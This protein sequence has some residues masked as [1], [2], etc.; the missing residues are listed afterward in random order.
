M[1]LQ[2]WMPLNGNLNNQG[3]N[4]D[5]SLMTSGTIAYTNNGKI[6]KALTTGAV[7]IPASMNAKIMN[8]NE[9]S[10]AF[11]VYINLEDG[12]TSNRSMFFGSDSLRWFSLFN[13]P[14]ANDLHW[15]W[16]N[17]PIGSS[18]NA[19]GVTRIS[20]GVKYGVIPTKK[21]FHL[22]ATYNRTK[23]TLYVDG[24]IVH[25]SNINTPA[26]VS[27]YA[28][29]IPMIHNNNYYYYND[30]RIYDHCLSSKE[31][32][33]IAK[34]L[35]LH[36]KL[37]GVGGNLIK[38]S[39]TAPSG[40]HDYTGKA[41]ASRTVGE[42]SV[43]TNIYNIT[44]PADTATYSNYNLYVFFTR[45]TT[46]AAQQNGKTYTLSFKI[47]ASKPLSS[48]TILYE[49]LNVTKTID[50]GTDWITVTMTGAATGSYSA[51]YL[52]YSQAN[53]NKINGGVLSIA[54]LKL[55]EGSIATPWT[56]NQSDTLYSK[57]GYNDNIEYD[58][59]GYRND[60]IK[61]G[62]IVSSGESPRHL[63]NH[64]F[65]G[66]SGI[67]YNNFYLGNVWS[68]GCW[69]FSPIAATQNWASLFC[70]NNNGG[71]TDLKMNIY[72]QQSSNAMQYSANGQYVLSSFISGV[73]HHAFETFD[74]TNLNCYLDGNLIATK[75]ITNTEYTRNNLVIGARSTAVDL[76]T[77]GVY[78][79][80]GMS[81][82]RIYATALSPEDIKELYEVGAHIDSHG[83][84][85]GYELKEE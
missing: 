38:D 26:N 20:S 51:L 15:D 52:C 25:T 37:N 18:F 7:T 69:F 72:V 64:I 19:S 68:A 39:L 50:V 59:S 49:Y 6:G 78:F 32:S 60:G 65:D 67:K 10:I 21:W 80:G 8:N 13:Y 62:S 81:D 23:I 16:C 9:F 28:S 66:S 63:S 61:I 3:L 43:A 57:L 83:N 34:G 47:K 56:P 73:W 4:D 76:S 30:Y 2:V 11:W 33:E 71:D 40:F 46:I 55:E 31:V 44:F 41:T 79:N 29:D 1:S 36:Y 12:A 70:V 75:T 85:Y 77:T 48:Y 22:A 74:G 35:C 82:F 45:D 5:I 54:D 24:E 58:C 17:T 14:S 53:R 27:S 42:G 84:V